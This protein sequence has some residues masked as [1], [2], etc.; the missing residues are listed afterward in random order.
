MWGGL[1]CAP[2]TPKLTGRWVCVG[3]VFPPMEMKQ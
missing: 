2:P 1:L 3:G